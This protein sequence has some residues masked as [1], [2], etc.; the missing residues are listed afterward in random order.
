MKTFQINLF[1]SPPNPTMYQLH[2]DHR[3][4]LSGAFVFA[5]SVLMFHRKKKKTKKQKTPPPDYEYTSTTSRTTIPLYSY[6]AL[7]TDLSSTTPANRRSPPRNGGYGGGGGPTYTATTHALQYNSP[8]ASRPSTASLA[9]L[10]AYNYSPYSAA[11]NGAPD[12]G[13]PHP[14]TRRD[15]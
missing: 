12:S 11:F 6:H 3:I 8:G 14:T 5:K 13:D 10:S 7:A 15:E 2:S 9:G 4:F 1:F